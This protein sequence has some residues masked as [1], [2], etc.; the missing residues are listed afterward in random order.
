M[1]DITPDL[2]IG[3]TAAPG[4]GKVLLRRILRNPNAAVGIAL[5][6]AM[7]AVAAVAPLLY[8]E[9]PM[10]LVARPMLWPGTDARFPLGTDSMG[11]DVLAGLMHGAR[12]SLLVGFSATLMGLL[13]GVTLGAVAG[14]F[15]GW[16]DTVIVK[17]I[18]VFQTVPSFV[19]LVVI[20]AVAE[21]SITTV[22]VSIALIS[23]DSVAR[24]A[25]GEF[26]ALRAR[27]FV[28]AARSQ[29]FSDARIIFSEIL[30]NALPSLIVTASIMVASAILMES[31]LSF[32]GLGDPNVVS[33][34]SMIG[35]GREML[36]TAW[37]LTALPGVAI[38]L[39][40]LAMNFLGDGLNDALNPRLKQ[41]G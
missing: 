19:L 24:L 9:D 4:R 7:F 21:P 14:Y 31:A 6:L 3:T 28:A 25:R 8:P 20:V 32:M 1:T 37:F 38:I 35:T 23:W 36:R 29:G 40:V 26:R 13:F 18:E 33:W 34:G 15:G 2:S 30:P 22:I 41:D 12:V 11:R 10:S 16:I 39:T 5:L 27:D 17:I